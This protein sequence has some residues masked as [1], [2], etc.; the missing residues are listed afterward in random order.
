MG[1]EAIIAARVVA[2]K[3]AITSVVSNRIAKTFRQWNVEQRW[4]KS[5]F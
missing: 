2:D 4:L 5:E 1:W 3:T